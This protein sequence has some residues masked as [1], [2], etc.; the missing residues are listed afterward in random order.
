[1]AEALKRSYEASLI[2]SVQAVLFEETEG[3]FAVGHA[4]NYI[5]VYVP[6]GDLHNRVCAVRLTGSHA[7]GMAGQ[8]V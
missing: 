5:K 3:D 1:M 4:P 7:D 8:L 6:G 2:G